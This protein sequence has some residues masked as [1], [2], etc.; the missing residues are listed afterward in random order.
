MCVREAVEHAL[1]R[2]LDEDEASEPPETDVS[3]RIDQLEARVKELEDF[4][5][6]LTAPDGASK[7][8][9]AFPVARRPEP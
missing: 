4:F 1:E 2:M 7:V 5:D 8:V 9:H 6:E 3:A